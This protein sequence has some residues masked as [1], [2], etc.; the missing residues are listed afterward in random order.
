MLKRIYFL[1]ALLRLG[2][3]RTC[4]FLLRANDVLLSVVLWSVETILYIYIYIHVLRTDRATHCHKVW[5]VFN[6]L[7]ESTSF[8]RGSRQRVR[9]FV[10]V[11]TLDPFLALYI[12]ALCCCV[13]SAAAMT[14]EAKGLDTGANNTDQNNMQTRTGSKLWRNIRNVNHVFSSRKRSSGAAAPEVG[15]T[16]ATYSCSL[17]AWQRLRDPQSVAC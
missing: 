2:C 14:R 8:F 13:L 7:V 5:C 9:A 10:C 6:N 16:D 12:T 15:V 17:H 3:L 11:C 4:P 1:D